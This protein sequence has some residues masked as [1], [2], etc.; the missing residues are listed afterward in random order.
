MFA[1]LPSDVS[2]MNEKNRLMSMAGAVIIY[3]TEDLR[4][5]VLKWAYMCALK[6]ECISPKS[7]LYS[8]PNDNHYCRGARPEQ[9]LYNCHRYDQSMLSILVNNFYHYDRSRFHLEQKDWIAT[10]KRNPWKKKL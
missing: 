2:K 10:T 8:P 4:N 1:F 6:N 3:N 7:E 9:D 5:G